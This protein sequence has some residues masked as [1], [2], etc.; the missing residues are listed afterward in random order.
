M[1]AFWKRLFGGSP[2]GL[3]GPHSPEMESILEGLT[4]EPAPGEARHRVALC[5]RALQILE[6]DKNPKLWA[7]LKREMALRLLSLTDGDRAVNVERAI[8]ALKDALTV[9]TRERM[10]A[11]WART[12]SNL[13]NA[14]SDRIYGDRAENIECSIA[15]LQEILEVRTR[16][17]APM[18]WAGTQM[19]LAIAFGNRLKGDLAEN[20][21]RSIQG[22]QAALEVWNPR[23]HPFYWATAQMNL[24]LALCRRIRGSRAENIE[25]AIDGFKLA[26]EVQAK[27]VLPPERM[28]GFVS[29]TNLSLAR[30]FLERVRGNRSENVEQAIC[31]CEAALELLS[32]ELMPVEWADAQISLANALLERDGGDRATN[33]EGAIE[34]FKPALEVLTPSGTPQL[35]AGAKVNLANAYLARLGDNSPDNVERA[36]SLCRE[37]LAVVPS[38]AMPK[39]WGAAQMALGHALAKRAGGD[40]AENVEQAIVCYEAALAVR[41]EEQTPISRAGLHVNLANAYMDRVRGDREENRQQA[42]KYYQE[43]LKVFSRENNPFD[44][45]LTQANLATVY[46]TTD[47]RHHA[48]LDRSIE[49]C[50]AALQVYTKEETPYKWADT[51]TN[52]AN[53]LMDTNDA[54]KVERAIE[55]HRGALE[56]W[57]RAASPV[58]WALCQEN[59]AS[60]YQLRIHGDRAENLRLAEAACRAA[61]EVLTADALPEASVKVQGRLGNVLFDQ[62][63]WE[64]AAAAYLLAT[65]TR[66]RLYSSAATEEVRHDLLGKFGAMDHR[67][68]YALVQ[69]GGEENLQQAT[70]ALELGRGRAVADYLLEEIL[71]FDRVEPSDRSDFEQARREIEALRSKARGARLTRDEYLR[72]TD[73]LRGAHNRLDEAVRRIRSYAPEFLAETDWENIREA[74]GLTTLIYLIATDVG[75]FGILVMRDAAV[76]SIPLPTFMWKTLI[77]RTLKYLPSLYEGSISQRLDSLDDMLRWLWDAA[78]GRLVAALD[79]VKEVLVVSGGMVS[80]LPLHA[81]WCPDEREPTRR[82]YAIDSLTFR[83]APNARAFL[84]A[85]RTAARTRIDR[86]LAVANPSPTLRQPLP[87]TE[88]EIGCLHRHFANQTIVL[89][90]EEAARGAVLKMLPE[91]TVLHFA[92]HGRVTPD[93]PLDNG[94][95]MAYDELLTLRDLM[96]LRLKKVRLAVLSACD[97]AVTGIALP[98]EVFGLPAGLMIA[99][100]DGVVGALWQVADA[101]SMLL[102]AQF[103]NG[104]VGDGLEPSEALAKAQRWMSATTLAEKEQYFR[105][106]LARPDAADAEAFAESLDADSQHPYFW[107]SFCYTGV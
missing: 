84:A 56:V 74:A 4:G 45:A 101:S 68:A 73:E 57:T 49:A 12:R 2:L 107:A 9:R 8:E 55:G 21:E 19:D 92:C 7:F 44:W 39:E 50:E 25:R 99:G 22:Y 15:G 14:Y 97:T 5:E 13:A 52:L 17:V 98:D 24:A 104:W 90:G 87:G 80:L 16:N 35:W 26:L 91:F 46:S 48:D 18:D 86:V 63:R 37:V 72:I 1:M 88:W 60:A 82:R 6:K 32:P 34:H 3:D 42:I 81:A 23:E 43:A 58:R 96:A 93:R 89:R 11:E 61:L 59:L 29:S 106:H 41:S 83:Y 10:P 85:H 27:A 69:A 105:T 78:I 77:D 28:Q 94:L 64:D 47:A 102:M 30:A 70:I 33:I 51:M 31:H 100:V 95:Y 71:S 54:D 66:D 67:L 62:E 76:R 36:I 53:A 103:Y 79:G 40:H 20:L 75:G 38:A 65:R